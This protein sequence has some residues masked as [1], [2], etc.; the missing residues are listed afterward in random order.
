[1]YNI[2]QSLSKEAE[3]LPQQG[4]FDSVGLTNTSC[5][6]T[7]EVIS[8]ALQ[9]LLVSFDVA[10]LDQRI[11]VEFRGPISIEAVESSLIRLHH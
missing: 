1:M 8:V 2:D 11:G 5:R 10:S 6:L 3:V 9:S 4:S 7:S